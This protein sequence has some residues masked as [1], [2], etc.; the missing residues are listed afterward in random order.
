MELFVL[1]DLGDIES[2]RILLGGFLDSGIIKDEREF[3]FL[4]KRLGLK[5]EP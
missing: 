3:R 1:E 2:A 5:N 4:Q